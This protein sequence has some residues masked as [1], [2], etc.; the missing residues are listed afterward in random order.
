MELSDACTTH[1]LRDLGLA[2]SL[3]RPL[4]PYDSWRERGCIVL[5]EMISGRDI[6]RQRTYKLHCGVPSR[7]RLALIELRRIHIQLRCRGTHAECVSCSWFSDMGSDGNGLTTL[8][9]EER[10]SPLYRFVSCFAQSAIGM[11]V[12]HSDAQRAD[13]DVSAWIKSRRLSKIRQV[14]ARR[15]R[16]EKTGFTF[17]RPEVANGRYRRGSRKSFVPHQ[18]AAYAILVDLSS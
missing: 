17:Q 14:N 9:P 16:G 18:D 8:S 6:D 4:L 3:F 7:P 15:V 13:W 2:G 5:G 1:L 10:S 12:T 11:I